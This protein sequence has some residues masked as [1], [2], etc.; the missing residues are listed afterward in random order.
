MKATTEDLSKHAAK[1]MCVLVFHPDDADDTEAAHTLLRDVVQPLVKAVAAGGDKLRFALAFSGPVM[2]AAAQEH[3]AV[4]LEVGEQV[5][6]G[7]L[8]ILGGLFYDAALALWPEADVR[9][10]I[11]MS[12]EYFESFLGHAPCG[13]WLPQTCWCIETPRLLAETG[14]DYGFIAADRVSQNAR[15]VETGQACLMRGGENLPAF[16]FK[17]DCILEDTS[18]KSAQTWFGDRAKALA[19]KTKDSDEKTGALWVWNAQAVAALGVDAF[20]ASIEALN[21]QLVLPQT[22]AANLHGAAKASVLPPAETCDPHGM[23][24]CDPEAASLHAQVLLAREALLEA[25]VIAE[26]ADQESATA[27][28]LATAQRHLF[29]AQM[30]QGYRLAHGE[31][32]AS[33][34]AARKQALD[35]VALALKLA[36][37]ARKVAEESILIADDAVAT[38]MP[39]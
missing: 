15:I 22:L 34:R 7:S 11:Q 24:R 19:L 6:R 36:A 13:F 5:A 37:Q 8:E 17:K 33:V 31:T 14:L 16:T 3:E 21:C 2:E 25:I 28:I 27:N 30:H 32:A 23:L 38:P 12:Q 18:L 20:L 10:Q 4:L 35:H 1:A 39:P 29:A 9:A 26:D